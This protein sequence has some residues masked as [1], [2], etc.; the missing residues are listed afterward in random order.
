V[1]WGARADD[2][3]TLQELQC[4][5]VFEAVLERLRVGPENRY[6][7]VGCGA[8]LAAQLAEAR[9]AQVSAFDASEPLLAIAR[10]RLKDAVIK[11][12]DLETL[13]FEDGAFDVVSGFNSFQYAANPCRA[14]AE[15][16]RVSKRGG[17]V[18]IMTWGPPEGMPA[19]KLVA[20]LRPL[21]PVPPAGA[22]GPFALSNEAALRDFARSA[23]LEPQEVFDV[24]SPF[25]YGSLD[26]GIRGLGSSGVAAKAR[27]NAGDEAVDRAHAEALAEFRQSD[28]SF[29]VPATFRCLIARA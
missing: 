28:G 24:E 1:L 5:P 18:A 4:K 21:M 13:P 11:Q 2:W 9:G 29:R 8:G 10:T 27:E 25:C 22:P 12:G 7:D 14:L 17:M 3:A 26:S 19:A 6:L 23:G 20:A 16:R 15:G